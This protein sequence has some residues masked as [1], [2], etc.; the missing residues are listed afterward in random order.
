M[1]ENGNDLLLEYWVS[2]VTKEPERDFC[3]SV[4]FTRREEQQVF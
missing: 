2:V 1:L 3:L 4:V